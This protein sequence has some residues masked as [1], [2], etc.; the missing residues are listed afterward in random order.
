MCVT[1][2]CRKPVQID[3][4]LYLEHK[5]K[6]EKVKSKKQQYFL[7]FYLPFLSVYL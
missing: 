1:A 3:D 4:A 5:N 6:T 7:S 2:L